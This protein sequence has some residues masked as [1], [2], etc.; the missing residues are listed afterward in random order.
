MAFVSKLSDNVRPGVVGETL[1]EGR[2]VQATQSGVRN[3]LTVWMTATA[4]ATKNVYCLMATPDRFQRPTLAGMYTAPMLTQLPQANNINNWQL[5]MESGVYYLKGKST[6]ENPTLTSGELGQGHRG[7]TYAVPSGAFIDS[8]GIKVPGAL[9]RVGVSGMWQV[10]TNE[11]EAVGI[12][13][14]YQ[15][16]NGH[17]YFTLNQ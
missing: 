12:V 14:E 3:E 4:N 1:Q 11:A 7:G 17:L 16:L 6:F 9:V 5:P 8:V 15:T 2:A 13:E 10:T